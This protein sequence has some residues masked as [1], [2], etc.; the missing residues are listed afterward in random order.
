VE[1]HNDAIVSGRNQERF[2]YLLIERRAGLAAQRI[3]TMITLRAHHSQ[4][5][6][7]GP[8]QPLPRLETK[9]KWARRV[10]ECTKSKGRYSTIRYSTDEGKDDV[11]QQGTNAYWETINTLTSLLPGE[12]K[13]GTDADVSTQGC[14]KHMREG[15]TSW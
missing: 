2:L 7:P 13:A 14:I 6:C 1:G 10:C 4:L 15:H 9:G 8:I 12:G 5:F 11:E 3:S